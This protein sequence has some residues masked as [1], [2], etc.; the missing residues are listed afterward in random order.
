MKGYVVDIEKETQENSFFRRVL[1][2]AK[3]SQLVLMNLKPKEDIGEEIHTLDQFIRVEVGKGKAILNGIEY[4]LTD[5]SGVV[6]PAGVKHNVINTG[7]SDMKIYTLYSPPEHEDGTIRKT[8]AE[9][10]SNEE[11]FNGKTTEQQK[12]RHN[13][14]IVI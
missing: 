13:L 14:K 5:G 6:I 7:E 1:Y 9:A 10:L 12:G 2:T 4:P 3:N 8:K 11:H